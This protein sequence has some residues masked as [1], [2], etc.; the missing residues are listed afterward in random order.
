[1]KKITS[2]MLL[3]LL[4]TGAFSSCEKDENK[5]FF[6]GGTAPVLASTAATTVPLSF[7]T[8]ENVATKITWTNPA[9]SFTTGVSSQDVS[10]EIQIDTTGANFTNP[11]KKSIS[12]ASELSYTF[13]Q[14]ELNDYLLNTLE[15]KAAIAHNIE[16]RVKSALGINKDAGILYSNVIKLR[17][18]PY[19]I[20]PKVELPASTKLYIV[21]SATPGG[22]GNPVPEPLQEMKRIEDTKFEITVQIQGGGSF[23][24]LPVNGSWDDKYG[25]AAAGN[26]NQ[27]NGDEFL[28]GGN[29]LLAPAASGT[30][31]I[32]V[33]FQTG[34]YRM[35]LL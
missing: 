2:Y 8:K 21:G 10:Y 15:L 31:K 22:W 7:A 18:T 5:I 24:F 34:K 13:I 27:V 11:K 23:L 26:A 17:A 6:E 33:D 19:A 9:Y 29:D 4:V 20:P 25:G 1:M 32:T 28:R 14:A 3:S 16:I 35:V 30:Y 12:I